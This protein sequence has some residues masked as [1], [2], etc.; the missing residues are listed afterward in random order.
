MQPRI[1]PLYGSR[2]VHEIAALLSNQPAVAGDGLVR[3]TWRETWKDRGDFE[4]L[5]RRSLHERLIAGSAAP[6]VEPRPSTQA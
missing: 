3:Q 5:W 1:R 4:S 2:S 6:A